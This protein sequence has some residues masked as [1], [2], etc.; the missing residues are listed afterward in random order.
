M[1]NRATSLRRLHEQPLIALTRAPADDKSGLLSGTR[2]HGLLLAVHYLAVD[3]VS[4]HIMLSNITEPWRSLRSGATP[5][6]LP[7]FTSYRRWC[8]LM[9][10]RADTA[11]IQAQGQYWLAQISGPDPVLACGCLA[12]AQT[13]GPRCKGDHTSSPH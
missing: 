2:P 12:R 9:W 7:E 8:E 1:P 6:A 10:R 13:L 5:R 3:V 4:R 11:D